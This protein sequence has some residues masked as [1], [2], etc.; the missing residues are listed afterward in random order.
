M[1]E[2]PAFALWLNS[3]TCSAYGAILGLAYV[4][5]EMCGGTV[6]D[7]E[8]TDTLIFSWHKFFFGHC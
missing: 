3:T 4:R 5:H 2:S 8:L 6:G 7:N 1:P